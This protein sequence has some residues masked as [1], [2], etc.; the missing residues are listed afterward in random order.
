MDID[1]SEAEYFRVVAIVHGEYKKRKRFAK[2]D[3]RKGGTE[4]LGL[5]E[6]S[7]WTWSKICIARKGQQQFWTYC[8]GIG[9]RNVKL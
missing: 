6:A 8:Q 2:V 7:R 9:C 4:V 1:R 3:L 5:E